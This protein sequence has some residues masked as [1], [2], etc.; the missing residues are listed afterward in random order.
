MSR[1][2]LDVAVIGGGYAGMAVAVTLVKSA[3]RATVF[4]SAKELGGRARRIAYRGETLDNGQHILSGAYSET[5]RLMREVGVADAALLRCPLMLHIPPHFSLTAPRW[6]APLHLAW[7][8]LTARGLTLSERFAAIKLMR[9]LRR[10]SFQL[11]PSETVESLLRAHDQPSTLVQYLW[12]PLTVSALNTP[13]ANASAQVFANVLRDALA[14]SAAASDLLLPTTDLSALF[15]DAAATWLESRGSRICTGSRVKSVTASAGGFTVESDAAS[16]KFDAVV[17]AIGPHQYDAIQLPAAVTIPAFEYEPILTV[18]LKFT[19]AV[20]LPMPMQGQVGELVQWFFDR[21]Q[22]STHQG[23]AGGLIA[24]V[25]S[26]SGAHDDLTQDELATRVLKELAAQ[27]GTLPLL[28]WHKV[29]SEKF[30]TFACT[31]AMHAQ[32][33]NHTTPIRGLMIAGDFVACDYPATLE[34]AVRNGILAAEAIHRDAAN[35]TTT[36]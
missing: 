6:P 19:Q 35:L 36:T 11:D 14:S 29:I 30:A 28:E 2:Q 17:I 21:R 13:I 1:P 26:A 12:E 16:Q 23:L 18:Y 33:P 9:V 10:Q 8:L 25:V 27:T 34:G 24:A 7:A 3:H 22:L 31:P 4:E 32:R 15:P 5:L 20:R